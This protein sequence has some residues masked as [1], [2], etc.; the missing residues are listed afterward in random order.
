MVLNFYG[1][2]CGGG[3]AEEDDQAILRVGMVRLRAG[4]RT[5]MARGWRP[6]SGRLPGTSC[7]SS[8]SSITAPAAVMAHTSS[9][10]A[11][12]ASPPPFLRF[13][14][15]S[16]FGTTTGSTTPTTSTTDSTSTSRHRRKEHE[17][18][19]YLGVLCSWSSFSS[20][21]LRSLTITLSSS[22]IRCHADIDAIDKDAHL[23]TPPPSDGLCETVK[24]VILSRVACCIMPSISCG[25]MQAGGN[26]GLGAGQRTTRATGAVGSAGRARLVLVIRERVSRGRYTIR[27]T[28]KHLLKRGGFRSRL[29]PTLTVVRVVRALEAIAARP[30][31][32][33][34]FFCS[35]IFRPSTLG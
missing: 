1:P 12:T 28:D 21:S 26:D 13:L 10:P 31:L 4:R 5:S 11:T 6:S 30:Q 14:R 33:A 34:S 35:A 27:E 19:L 24:G 18:R 16:P 9:L 20:C 15:A 25:T 23:H 3:L 22:E 32:P 8:T 2:F 29:R 17:D 7:M